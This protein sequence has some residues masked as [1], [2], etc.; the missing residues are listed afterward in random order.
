MREIRNANLTQSSKSD[1]VCDVY[2]EIADRP[3]HDIHPLVPRYAVVHQSNADLMEEPQA[4]DKL[5]LRPGVMHIVQNVVALHLEVLAASWL[6]GTMGASD[7]LIQDGIFS[8]LAIIPADR[9]QDVG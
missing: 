8:S 3:R 9:F 1:D 5:I 7:T 4:F 6:R 2:D